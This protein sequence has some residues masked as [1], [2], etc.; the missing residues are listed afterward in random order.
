MPLQGLALLDTALAEFG[1]VEGALP[2]NLTV[3]L[4]DNQPGGTGAQSG[5]VNLAV[6][7]TMCNAADN[8]PAC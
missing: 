3:S 2:G 6:D 1:V 7:G 5:T 8:A 4:D